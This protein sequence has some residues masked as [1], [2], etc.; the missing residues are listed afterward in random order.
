MRASYSLVPI[1][2][3]L[4]KGPLPRRRPRLAITENEALRKAAGL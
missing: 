4:S 3:S 2:P 1:T